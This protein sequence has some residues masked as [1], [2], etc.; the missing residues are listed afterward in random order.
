MELWKSNQETDA[1]NNEI[2][3]IFYASSK[4][5]H[6]VVRLGFIYVS[7][8]PAASLYTYLACI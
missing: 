3:V 7:E 8:D 5:W 2:R 4:V 1:I 6:S